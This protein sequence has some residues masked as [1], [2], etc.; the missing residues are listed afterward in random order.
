VINYEVMISLLSSNP[1]AFVIATM[2]LVIA[3]TIHE[4]AHAFMADY[5]GDPTPR[6]NGRTTLNP[7]AHLDPLGTL[8]L[9]LFRFGWGKPVG[10]D[11]YNLKNPIRDTSL[12][13]LAGPA[14]NLL[15]AIFLAIFT[16]LLAVPVFFST[17][18]EWIIYL[19]V[20]LAVFNLVPVH[21]LDGSKIILM[22]LPA[23]TA[24][25]YEN[26]MHRY[27]MIVLVLLI[28][29]WGGTSPIQQLIWPVIQFIMNILS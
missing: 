27:G 24:L 17:A 14:S 10:F 25:E 2:G 19:N 29:P 4:A 23:N 13:A 7:R 15:L 11:P 3:I 9:L 6:A 21:P 22:F 28:L 16:K 5:L 18:V 20:M 26:F 1:I 8:M 12:I